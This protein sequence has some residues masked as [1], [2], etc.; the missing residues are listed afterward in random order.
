MPTQSK[1]GQCAT[2]PLPRSKLLRAGD[3]GRVSGIFDR[4]SEHLLDDSDLLGVTRRVDEN[5]GKRTADADHAVHLAPALIHHKLGIAGRE[6]QMHR[7]VDEMDMRR[8][9]PDAR[10][11]DVRVARIGM[12]QENTLVVVLD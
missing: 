2:W 11:D 9:A 4:R 6:D 5:V 3:S 10:L 1:R 8:F 7:A 12:E